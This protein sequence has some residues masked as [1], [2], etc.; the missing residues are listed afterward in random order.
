MVKFKA[1]IKKFAQKGEKTGWT[2]VEIPH[3]IAQKIKPNTKVAYRVKGF[4]DDVEVKALAITPMGNGDFILAL[5]A[6]SR[7]LIKKNLGDELSLQL[8]E[9]KVGYQLDKAFLD[10]LQFEPLAFDFFN[11]LTKGH[12]NYFSKWIDSAKTVETKSKRIAMAVNA[13][14]KKWDYGLMIRTQVAENRKLKGYKV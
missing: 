13:L 7:K 11:T 5:N 2:Y 8:E 6:T 9:D 12:Q 10:C 3:E 1:I 14:A 4:L